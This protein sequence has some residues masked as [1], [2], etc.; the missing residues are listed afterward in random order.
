MGAKHL[1]AF[2][3]G[4]VVT[5][6]A[7]N[8]MAEAVLVAGNRI[9]AIGSDIGIA[10]MAPAAEVVDLAGRVLFPGFIE[11][12]A[13]VMGYGLVESRA[14]L[15][16]NLNLAPVRSRRDLLDMVADEARGR[17]A[18]EWIMGRGFPLW[19]WDDPALPT[20]AELDRAAPGNPLFL[21]DMSGHVDV[22]NSLGLAAMG[23]TAA[24]PDPA[25][26]RIER[27]ASG[28]PTGVLKDGAALP[29]YDHVPLPTAGEYLDA[30][31]VAA[32][33]LVGMGVT[34]VHTLRNALPGGYRSDQYRPF[35]ELA[36][37]GEL[38]LTVR[39]LVEAYRNIG[40][41]G[42]DEHLRALTGLGL[43]TGFGDRVVIGGVKILSDGSLDSRTS[44]H[45]ED[46]AD[47]PGER[48]YMWRPP[49]DYAAMI[50]HAHGHGLQIAVHC[51]GE[52][53][54]DVILDA[55]E[56][57]LEACPRADHRH[58]LEHV[59]LLSD[60]Q[61]ERIRRLGLAVCAAPSF[62]FEPR[63]KEMMVH[64]FGET[65][66]REKAFRYRTL[67]EAGVPVFGGSDCHPCIPRWINPLGQIRLVSEEGPFDASERFGREQAVRMWT[68]EA[69]RAGFEEAS[70]GS[71]EVGKRADL[72]VLS[73]NPLE[74]P[75]AALENIRVDLTMVDGEIVH[76]R[77]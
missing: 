24:T 26:G 6:D 62:R 33:N 51:N 45:Y 44:C 29:L 43:R 76:D 39:L 60:N 9:A 59:P 18:G 28:N 72:V 2:R 7:R 12:H 17:P 63:F 15:F 68:S 1:I 42:D 66:V 16:M 53:S 37:R 47:A 54:T 46:F 61:I 5:L 3:N 35:M 56:D 21:I 36:Q 34:T 49:G 70:K 8:T 69:A 25:N 65:R 13:H 52:R 22:T 74:V 75:G 77:R 40:R 14:S 58:R 10:A 73:G 55:F 30:V 48:G 27:D 20:L 38:P 4:R 67:A 32:A 57:A 64:L 11:C 23:Y 71:I 19:T 41:E 31:R 50:R